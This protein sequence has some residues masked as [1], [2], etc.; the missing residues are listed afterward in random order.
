MRITNTFLLLFAALIFACSMYEIGQERSSSSSPLY[1]S[2]SSSSQAIVSQDSTLYQERLYKTVKIGSQIW[3]TENLNAVPKSGNCWC[4][5][6]M[7]EHCSTYGKLCD[8]KAAMN[9][10]PDGWKLP[11]KDDYEKLYDYQDR[12]QASSVWDAVFGGYKYDDGRWWPLGDM[13]FWWSSTE[14]GDFAYSF[15]ITKGQNQLHKIYEKKT[16]GLSVRCIK[17]Q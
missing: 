6:D 1:S 16:Y 5:N 4:Y 3:L 14:S 15:Y 9:V 10:C 17:K 11:S 7:D 12:L 2:H 8:W 13:G